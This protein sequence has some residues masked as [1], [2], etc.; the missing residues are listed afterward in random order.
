MKLESLLYLVGAEDQIIAL[1][2]DGE[3]AAA[4]PA[5][6]CPSEYKNYTVESI[7]PDKFDGEGPFDGIV[8]KVWATEKIS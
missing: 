2:V 3:W 4:F 6:F 8:L 7:M 5:L 1:L